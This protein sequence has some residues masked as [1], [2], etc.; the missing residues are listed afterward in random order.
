MDVTC[1]TR[2]SEEEL[3]QNFGWKAWSEDTT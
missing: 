1:A 2:V 3:V